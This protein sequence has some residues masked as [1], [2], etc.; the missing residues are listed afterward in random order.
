[1]YL[2]WGHRVIL[3][4]DGFI[5][6]PFMGSQIRFWLFGLNVWW[7][8]ADKDETGNGFSF[9]CGFPHTNEVL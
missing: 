4:I 2:I 1:M 8:T 9:Y 3:G 6:D 7:A 5:K